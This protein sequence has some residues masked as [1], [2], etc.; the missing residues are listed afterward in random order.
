MATLSIEAARMAANPQ[1]KKIASFSGAVRSLDNNALEKGDKFTFPN[2]YEVYEQKLGDSTVQLILVELENGQAKPFYPS[3]FT[4]SRQIYN[5]DLTPT[6]ERVHTKGTAAEFF[7]TFGNVAEAMNALKGKT[8]EVT[9]IDT[10][11]TKRYG[12]DELVNAQIFTIDF[13]EV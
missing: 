12:V 9:N 7:R 2:K 10:I 5:E 4:K 11:R 3:T 13:V 8:V 6:G 1:Y